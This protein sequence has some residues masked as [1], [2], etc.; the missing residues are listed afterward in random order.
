MGKKKKEKRAAKAKTAEKR[1]RSRS[2]KKKRKKAAKDDRAKAQDAATRCCPCCKKH[3]PLSSPKC[4]KG[5]KLA[6]KLGLGSAT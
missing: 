6:K 1:E 3:C 4:S 2:E 5:R